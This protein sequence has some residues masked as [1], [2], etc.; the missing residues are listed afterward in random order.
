[1]GFKDGGRR[2]EQDGREGEREWRSELVVVLDESLAGG[3]MA[4]T[5]EEHVLDS[6]DGDRG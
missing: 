3:G 1:M 6:L 2:S 5:V 4:W